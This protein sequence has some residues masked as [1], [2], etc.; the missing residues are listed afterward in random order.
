[1]MIEALDVFREMTFAGV[2]LR[3]VLAMFCGG[4]IGMNRERMRRPK[5]LAGFRTYMMVSVG[6][7]LTMLLSQYDYTMITTQWADIAQEV[8]ITS[9]VSRLSAQVINGIGF[10]GAG[11][12]LVTKD[13][14]VKGLT[15]AA[16]LWASACLGIAIGAGF[17]ECAVIAVALI[18]SSM[19]FFAAIK[20]RI[21]ERSRVV[22]IYV[23]MK[24]LVYL[25]DVMKRV[26]QQGG[27]L[28]DLNIDNENRKSRTIYDAELVI[29]LPAGMTPDTMLA[30]VSQVEHVKHVHE[31]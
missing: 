26:R 31:L 25:A 5:G 4:L 22:S 19:V 24:S 8:G 3:L 6:A 30:I 18:L 12:I 20:R 10:L 11:T 7:A 2:A 28:V 13:N 27:S 9:D 1:M 14:Q 15:T 21:L 29:H 16:G 23:E 17:F